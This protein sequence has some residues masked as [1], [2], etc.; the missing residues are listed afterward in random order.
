[1]PDHD[2]IQVYSGSIIHAAGAVHCIVMHVP[3]FSDCNENGIPDDEDIAEGTSEDC[4]P[5]GIPDECETDCQ[6]NDVPD[7]CDIRGGT[8]E[9]CNNNAVPDECDISQGTS[10]DL[11]G[12]G[13]PDECEIVPPLPEDSLGI[14]NCTDDDECD[15]EA[16]CVEGVC[17]APKHRYISIS[18][19]PDQPAA[20]A[21]RIKL[22]SGETLG[23]VGTPYQNGGL[24]FAD[25]VAGSVYVNPWPSVVHVTGCEIATG[26]TYLI[27]TIALGQEIGD[28]YM[29]SEALALH[30]PS[31]WGDTVTSGPG[32][33]FLPPDGV[34]GLADIMA[35][36]A[37]FQGDTTIAPLTW[38]DIAPSSGSDTPNQS[39]GLADI[40]ACVAGF[41]GE[42][43][44]GDGP[45][46]CP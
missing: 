33:V 7:D 44:P 31:V 1:M 12:N 6:P 17:Y 40:M 3:S 23:W 30:T 9:D 29:Y 38:L 16:R 13:I 28:E 21:R 41:Q 11:N 19:N 22:Q 18:P 26:Q 20:T 35:A 43:Y 15:Y 25:V 42:L 2:I 5:N 8:S 37:Y 24:D 36:V 27:Q 32:G 34:P 39:V 14:T 45:S 4:Q 46:G 10:Q